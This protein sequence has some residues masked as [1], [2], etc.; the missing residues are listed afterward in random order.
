MIAIF[1]QHVFQLFSRR[2]MQLGLWKNRQTF[3]FYINQIFINPIFINGSTICYAKR[4]S[5][6]HHERHTTN[7]VII[8]ALYGTI[9]NSRSM[10]R[11]D[12]QLLNK[13]KEEKTKLNIKI[14]LKNTTEFFF[15]K[16]YRT[17][18]SKVTT[19]L[20]LIKCQVI[21]DPLKCDTGTLMQ[22]IISFFLIDLK[23][24]KGG[25][26]FRRRR[27][28]EYIL[29]IGYLHINNVVKCFL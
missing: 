19:W 25:E 10:S 11:P 12:N 13:K 17:S 3:E 23:M 22:W 26:H 28:E 20:M 9:S 27:R 18:S 1:L 16:R 8:R 24:M 14:T 7:K 21:A 2:R 5:P 15:P 6:V 29:S 4:R